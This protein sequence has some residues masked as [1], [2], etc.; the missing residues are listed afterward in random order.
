MRGFL[1]ILM[2]GA[3]CVVTAQP[4]CAGAWLREP[5]TTFLSITATIRNLNGFWQSENSLYAEFGAS[6]RMTLGLDINDIPGT[7]GHALVFARVPIGPQGK[8][9][10]LALELGIGG[11]QWQGQWG[12][13]IKTTFSVGRDFASR[14]GDGW[15]DIDTGVELRRPHPRFIY[16]GTGCNKGISGLEGGERRA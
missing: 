9:T 15:L 11:H 8:R 14:W 10:K 1:K 4:A 13:M 7:A 6:R 2:L 12:E 3:F 16:A 5:D